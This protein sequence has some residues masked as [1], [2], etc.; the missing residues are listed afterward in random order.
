MIS[1]FKIR[2]SLFLLIAYII[3]LYS[4]VFVA[5]DIVKFIE[6]YI[7]LNILINIIGS[8]FALTISTVFYIKFRFKVKLIYLHLGISLLVII[9][10]LGFIHFEIEK[11]HFIEYI[12]L[13]VLIYR[14]F[15]FNTEG[16][17]LII[18]TF[19]LSG[20]IGTTDEIVQYFLPNRFFDVRDIML[21]WI[22]S[23]LGVYLVSVYTMSKFSKQTSRIE[24]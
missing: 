23:L 15:S 17:M 1:S 8:I 10:S 9:Y 5:Y 24:N 4:T 14:A 6:Q 3:F 21:N 19:I 12:V 18:L 20:F 16:S 13:G 7:S 11:I 22:G 2:M